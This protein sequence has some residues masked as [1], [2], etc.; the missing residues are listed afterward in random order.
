MACPA[1][2][3]Q[4]WAIKAQ[5]ASAI[6][7][8]TEKMSKRQHKLCE[9]LYMYSVTLYYLDENLGPPHLS[10]L[11]NSLLAGLLGRTWEGKVCI[12]KTYCDI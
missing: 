12:I 6:A 10:K 4:S 2:E 8:I 3:A 7:T 11:M 1:L 5:G 9:V